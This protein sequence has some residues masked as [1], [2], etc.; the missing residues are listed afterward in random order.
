MWFS[1]DVAN[2]KQTEI[3]VRI[4]KQEEKA[5]GKS[6]RERDNVVSKKSY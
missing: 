6:E 3:L 2:N 4:R 1:L 5:E